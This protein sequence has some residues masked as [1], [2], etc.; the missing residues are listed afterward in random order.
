MGGFSESK[1]L[2]LTICYKHPFDF[3]L[4]AFIKERIQPLG[5]EFPPFHSKMSSFEK[6]NLTILIL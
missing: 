6:L 5:I 2:T 3:N 1:P 4:Q